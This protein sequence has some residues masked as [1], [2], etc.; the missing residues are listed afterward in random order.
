M[1][2]GAVVLT[3]EK[4]RCIRRYAKVLRMWIREGDS[5]DEQ[6][7]QEWWTLPRE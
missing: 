1:V 6:P 7:A 2:Y 4:A 3:G 5:L